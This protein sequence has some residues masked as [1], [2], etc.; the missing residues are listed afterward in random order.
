MIS[1]GFESALKSLELAQSRVAV[2]IEKLNAAGVDTS[3]AT[4]ALNL[5]KS[6]LDEA[7]VKIAEV[8]ALIPSTDEAVTAEVFEQIKL[9]ARVAK[10]L[11]K[12]SHENIKSAISALKSSAPVKTGSEN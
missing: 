3:V 2:V 9:G 6:K 1:L 8:K 4:D 5:S 11:L 10:D 7:K 12:E